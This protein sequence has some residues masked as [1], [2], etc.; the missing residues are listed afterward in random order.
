MQQVQLG[1]MVADAEW[2]MGLAGALGTDG[3]VAAATGQT[4]TDV[5]GPCIE[6][7][8]LHAEVKSLCVLCC[9]EAG[10]F[11]YLSSIQQMVLCSGVAC[12]SK[13]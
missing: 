2:G 3:V 4:R 12:I 6:P 10:V 8:L 9:F 5:L 11:V 1:G 13:Q 7:E